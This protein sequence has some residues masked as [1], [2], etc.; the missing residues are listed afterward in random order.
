MWG[1]PGGDSTIFGTHF[2]APRAKLQVKPRAK[3]QVKS[4]LTFSSAQGAGK[5]IV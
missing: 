2:P 3:L 5:M 4:Y 1:E